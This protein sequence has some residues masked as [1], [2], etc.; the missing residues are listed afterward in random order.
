MLTK[1]ELE[2][3]EVLWS[4]GRPLSRGEIL[5]LSVEKSWKSSSIHILLNNM[6]SKG[7]IQ[8][9]GFAK[10]G[11]TCG[12]LYAPAFA[13][14]SYY[15]D[16]MFSSSYYRPNLTDLLQIMIDSGDVSLDE[17]E[18]AVREIGRNQKR[19]REEE[20]Y[21]LWSAQAYEGAPCDWRNH[22]S[23]EEKR[24]VNDLDSEA[25]DAHN[26]RENASPNGI[27]MVCGAILK[28]SSADYEQHGYDPY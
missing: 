11:K 20:I 1:N 13:A 12:R 18:L 26:C 23:D 9:A 2:I 14:E 8:E 6:L 5:N 21:R 25:A 17:L 16:L 15:A 7:L 22:L 10:T 19:N 27:C 24:Y 3:M 4:A 28:G